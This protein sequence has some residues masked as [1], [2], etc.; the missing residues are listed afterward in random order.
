V[1]ARA[2]SAEALP[3]GTEV[4]VLRVEQGIA[5]VESFDPFAELD[6]GAESR[7]L[8]ARRRAE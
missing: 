5:L 4:L 6:Q 7:T 8:P 1:A 3:R 2:A